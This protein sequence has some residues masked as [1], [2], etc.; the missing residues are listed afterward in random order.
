M[1]M[2][3]ETTRRGVLRTALGGASFAVAAPTILRHARGDAPI[4]IGMPCALTGPGG[5]VGLCARRS[6][7]GGQVA[8]VVN[9][10]GVAKARKS[11]F[12]G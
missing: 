8:K 7:S 3:C 4:K 5:E 9:Y 11:A 6:L 12:S 10:Q 1:P 2:S